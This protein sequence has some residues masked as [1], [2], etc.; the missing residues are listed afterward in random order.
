MFPVINP[1]LLAS[2]IGLSLLAL[3]ALMLLMAK[4]S[5]RLRRHETQTLA[6][7]ESHQQLKSLLQ[8]L[9]LGVILVDAQFQ[10]HLS[11]QA[12]LDMLRLTE[13]QLFG[14]TAL[15]AG[16]FATLEDEPRFTN[17]VELLRAIAQFAPEQSQGVGIY[18]AG[19]PQPTWLLVTVMSQHTPEGTLNRIIYTFSNITER[20]QAE[21]ALL[22]QAKRERLISTIAQRIRQ[23][24]NLKQILNTTVAEVRQHLKANRVV[25]GEIHNKT[26]LEVLAESSDSDLVPSFGMVLRQIISVERYDWY[27]Q[28]HAFILHDTDQGDYPATVAD[29]IEQYQVKSVAI[30]PILQGDVLWGLLIAQQAYPANPWTA[31]D[32]EFLC[33]LATQVAIA[34]RQSQLYQQVQQFNLQLESQ[35]AER[36]EQLEQALEFEAT[37]K[38]ITDKVRDSLDEGQILQSAVQE[39]GLVLEASSCNAALYDL[40]QE[41]SAV[42]YEYTVSNVA[43]RGRVMQMA[44]RP[45]LYRQLRR[46]YYFQFCSL[47]PH[48]PRGQAVM[49]A[50]PILDN[51]G[52]IGDLWVVDEQGHGFEES[53]IRLVQQ[54]ANQCAI[55]IRQARL[56]QYS[57]TQVEELER[58]NRLKDDFL[59]TVSH[60]LRTPMSNMKMA[61][62]MLKSLPSS[63]RRQR[64]LEILETECGREVE[65]INDLLDLQRLEASSY[66]ASLETLQ[67]QNWLP[68]VIGPFYSRAAEY[69]Q[70][71]E[72]ICPDTLPPLVS[73]VMALRRVLTELLNNACKYTMAGGKIILDVSLDRD[74]ADL[75]NGICF[76]VLNQTE[77]PA[78]EL[79]HI[80]EKF[81]RIPNGDP[82]SRGGTGLGLALVKKLVEQLRGSIQVNSE[83]GWTAFIVKLPMVISDNMSN[84]PFPAENF[85]AEPE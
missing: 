57:Q 52:V 54:V 12:A 2:L 20:K 75:K 5:W 23:S 9:H 71:L 83:S 55:A 8:E 3:L 17:V 33:Q 26:D 65:L 18:S 34:I 11:N 40:D 62:H 63:D 67:L 53:Q 60:E 28:G 58:L 29:M 47:S 6:V 72:M 82:W 37:L 49:L 38:R 66:P 78:H 36:T 39:L 68:S 59:S 69:E 48:S 42:C 31:S 1:P 76:R 32:I 21:I 51:E 24:L 10:I 80:F 45:E 44:N 19:I 73:D 16:W 70:R 43:Y 56:Y 61:I 22:E 46:G 14:T 79:P 81:Y 30:A 84:S 27:R 7:Q 74:R 15:N 13:A 64:Y 50:C 4:L 41:I 35:V 85:P 77:I 25:I